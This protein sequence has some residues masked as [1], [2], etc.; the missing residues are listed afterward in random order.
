MSR[1]VKVGIIGC[2]GIANGKHMPSLSKLPEVQMVAFCDIVEEKAIAAKESAAAKSKAV[3]ENKESRN[4]TAEKRK[5]TF[6]EKREYEELEKEIAALEEEKKALEDEMS[7][8]TL[9]GN[10]LV[11]KSMRVAEIIDLLDDK[12]MRWLELS[13]WA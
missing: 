9:T 1:I 12:G 10:T 2:G 3:K 13:E 6:K 11:E 5:L 7:S 4:A 8:G